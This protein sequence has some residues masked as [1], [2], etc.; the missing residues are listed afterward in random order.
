LVSTVL[1]SPTGRGEP[2]DA[3]GAG[4]GAGGA[5]L[6]FLPW[7]LPAPPRTAATGTGAAAA[8]AALTA[9]RRLLAA[10]GHAIVALAPTAAPPPYT[11]HS[12]LVIPA[13]D[14]AGLRYLQH[15]VVTTPT[16]P[17]ASAQPDDGQPAARDDAMAP[18]L[19]LL[20][21]GPRGRTP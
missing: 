11:E 17:P 14:R 5:R 15:I 16:A 6:A 9:C 8:D 2:D 10:D 12:Q 13:A 19:S 1:G 20:V 21:F 4:Q 18:H 7:P 3:T